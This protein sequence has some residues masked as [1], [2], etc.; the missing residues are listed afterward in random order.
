MQK[1][2]PGTSS[3]IPGIYYAIVLNHTKS[4]YLGIYMYKHS[5]SWCVLSTYWHV[6]GTSCMYCVGRVAN[7]YIL[8]H[9]LNWNNITGMYQD[10]PSMYQ[11]IRDKTTKFMAVHEAQNW[12]DYQQYII[13][14]HYEREQIGDIDGLYKAYIHCVAPLAER[15]TLYPKVLGSN[16]TF[17][18][19]HI[20][21]L[22]PAVGGLN[23]S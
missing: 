11:Y 9:T 10:K 4:S 14:L 16:T 15:R 13:P 21:C 20:T 7:K 22:S 1:D 5:M 2:V 17:S 18:T 12:T 6:P 19:K 3:N 8:N 23:W